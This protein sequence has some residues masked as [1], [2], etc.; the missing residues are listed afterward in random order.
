MV[1]AGDDAVHPVGENS[2]A[3]PSR[4]GT[5]SHEWAGIGPGLGGYSPKDLVLASQRGQVRKTLAASTIKNEVRVNQHAKDLAEQYGTKYDSGHIV[6]H[7]FGGSLEP[8]RPR[9]MYQRVTAE[10]RLTRE[11]LI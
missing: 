8:S 4:N 7:Q 9:R 1:G 6:G 3:R 2:A 10:D 11:R 5:R